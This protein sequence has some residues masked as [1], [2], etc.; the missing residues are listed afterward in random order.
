[1][2]EEKKDTSPMIRSKRIIRDI[3]IEEINNP[4]AP[5]TFDTV[6][7]YRSD[8]LPEWFEGLRAIVEDDTFSSMMINL[9]D[10]VRYEI[11]I[12]ANEDQIKQAMEALAKKQLAVIPPSVAQWLKQEG[13]PFPGSYD[14]L[15]KI[16]WRLRGDPE[17]ERAYKQLIDDEEE[18]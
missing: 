9:G 17:R 2:P 13:T 4:P 5:N 18:E 14:E 16:V 3:R 7:V 15:S 1:M 8:D 12:A 6:V 11:S 10:R